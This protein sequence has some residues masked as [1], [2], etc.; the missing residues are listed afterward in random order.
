MKRII[1][2]ILSFIMIFSLTAS[3]YVYAEKSTCDINNDGE[4]NNKDVAALFRHVCSEAVT[5]SC[6]DHDINGDGEVN[7]KDV[8]SLFRYVSGGSIY[9]GSY[10]VY[11]YVTD[12]EN[13][14]YPCAYMV[15]ESV[16]DDDI[17]GWIC[18]EGPGADIAENVP[19]LSYDG[20]D[21]DIVWHST[22]TETKVSSWLY[23]SRQELNDINEFL[24]TAP[25]GL[26]RFVLTFTV[27]GR[28]VEDT[29]ENTCWDYPFEVVVPASGD[30]LVKPD[31]T[32]FTP[33]KQA[34]ADEYYLKM[35]ELYP[36][37]GQIPRDML[38]EYVFIWED[39][40][41]TVEFEF[42]YG[43][44]QTDCRCRFSTSPKYPEGCWTLQENGFK[45]F[46][47]TGITA[48]EMKKI[49]EDLAKQVIDYINEYKL[50]NKVTPDKL[51][52][53]C[54]D[55]DGKL[56]ICTE[57]IAKVTEQTTTQFGCFDHAHVFGEYV[58]EDYK[59]GQ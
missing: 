3:V 40:Y 42:C 41:F 23:N 22:G 21:L 15:G 31:K 45:K 52:I 4:V 19:V 16:Y 26:Y 27:K 30:E 29:Y 1:V 8:I 38:L 59:G 44:A 33:D 51:L 12:G 48:A 6:Y 58:I 17:K 18:A 55:Y 50:E 28:F 35:K 5:K 2:I 54:Q 47:Q 32:V 24:K 7:N 53:F 49:R 46:Y 25:A 10:P 37:F 9:E 20:S 13:A 14:V 34:L 43:G 57:W 36:E 11:L 39:G 56:S